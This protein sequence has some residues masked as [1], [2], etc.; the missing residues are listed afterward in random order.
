MRAR[1]SLHPGGVALAIEHD[2]G[3]GTVILQLADVRLEVGDRLEAGDVVGRVAGV[4]RDP[5]RRADAPH[6]ILQR[7]W[8]GEPVPWEATPT[9][10]AFDAGA[11][12]NGIAACRDLGLRGHLD[13]LPDVEERA[14]ALTLWR[15]IAPESFTRLGR[16]DEAPERDLPT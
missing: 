3:L 2:A 10:V 13:G 15:V 5:R 4:S 11:V 16:L 8:L 1:V 12:E 6:V 9:H 7:V 14:W